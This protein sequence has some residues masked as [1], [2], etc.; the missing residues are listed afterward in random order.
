LPF[1]PEDGGNTFLENI[2]KLVQDYTASYP[3][4]GTVHSHQF[5][6]FKSQIFL[7]F[8]KNASEGGKSCQG[9]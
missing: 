5:E 3:E 9:L 1:Y 8:I 2:R 4:D 7:Y 6:N